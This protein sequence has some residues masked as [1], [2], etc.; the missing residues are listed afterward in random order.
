MNKC[1][2][3]LIAFELLCCLLFLGTA[4]ALPRVAI[5]AVASAVTEALDWSVF[6]SGGGQAKSGDGVVVIN[7][8][9]GQPVI[10][11]ASST[12][13]ELGSGIWIKDATL[14]ALTFIYLPILKR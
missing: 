7:S 12:D 14:D 11:I 9:I 4:R 13:L 10:G 2:L 1:K 5:A 3:T 8:T 6:G